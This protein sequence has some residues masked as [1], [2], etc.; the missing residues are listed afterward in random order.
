MDLAAFPT[1]VPMPA[2][3]GRLAG[4]EESAKKRERGYQ[5]GADLLQCFRW[6]FFFLDSLVSMLM[7]EVS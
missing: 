6:K 7:S 1:V 5:A 4:L 2:E 3:G